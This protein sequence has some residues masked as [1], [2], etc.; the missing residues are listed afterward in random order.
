M[1]FDHDL[2]EAQLALHHI[3]ATDMPKLAWDALEVGLD[4]PATRRLAALHFPTYFQLRQILPAVMQ[5]WRMTYL[6]PKDA[7]V[8]LAKFRARQILQNN[9]DPLK[10]TN[11]FWR[12]WVDSDYC[13]ALHDYGPLA[14]DVHVARESGQTDDQI[15]ASVLVKLKAL[16]TI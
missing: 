2:V 16:A 13:S 3:G 15:R 8:R 9:E 10:H 6:S 1:P 4:G 7:A 12:L 11:D 14:D 5:E